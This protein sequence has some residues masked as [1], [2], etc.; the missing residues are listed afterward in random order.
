MGHA[1]VTDEHEI[2][3]TTGCS[4][5]GSIGNVTGA[6]DSPAMRRI[7][8]CCSLQTMLRLPANCPR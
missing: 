4:R 1:T 5:N 2:D 7:S 8:G 6:P 3:R